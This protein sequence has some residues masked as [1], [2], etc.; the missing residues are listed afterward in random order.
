M[1]RWTPSAGTPSAGP[2]KI[3][4][5]FHLAPQ[6]SSVPPSLW[7]SF[8]GILVVFSKAL[9]CARLA[10]QR[11]CPCNA[12]SKMKTHVNVRCTPGRNT[13]REIHCCDTVNGHVRKHQFAQKVSIR[14][15]NTIRRW[16]FSMATDDLVH[17]D[18]GKTSCFGLRDGQTF[19]MLIFHR[20]HWSTANERGQRRFRC[21]SAHASPISVVVRS[22]RGRENSG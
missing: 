13:T 5:F 6:F 7:R 10:Q 12:H 17:R 18:P 22:L 20:D 19:H 15:Q 8:R 9:K 4:R 1:P 3:S 16:Q 21:T 11:S 14:V 2:P